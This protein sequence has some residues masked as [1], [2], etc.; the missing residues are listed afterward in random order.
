MKIFKFALCAA[1]LVSTA[2]VSCVTDETSNASIELNE[3]EF[4]GIASS[5]TKIS[6]MENLEIEPKLKGSLYGDDDTKY[7]YQWTICKSVD[8]YTHA[9]DFIS[10]E[11]KLDYF[12]DLAPGVYTVT[13]RVYDKDNGMNYEKT[14]TL[15][16]ESP[17]VRGFY[18][19]G[20]KEDGLAAMDFVSIITG[21]DTTLIKDVFDN[22]VG[23]KH[24]VDLVYTG[25]YSMVSDNNYAS[26]E[27]IF[28]LW[29]VGKDASY[30][31]ESLA[32]L[33][34]FGVKDG[35]RPENFIFSQYPLAQPTIVTNI[36][37][38]AFGSSNINRARSYRILTTTDEI[39]V[40]S[41]MSEEAYGDP[42][43]RY[44]A[45]S[46]EFF[47]P[48][49]YMFY[50]S[51][52]QTTPPVVVAYDL[53]NHKFCISNSTY[54]L[55]SATAFKT[56]T[57][58]GSIFYHDQ[59]KYTPVRDLIYGEN[60]LGRTGRCYALMGDANGGRWV[61][62]FT[63]PTSGYSATALTKVRNSEIDMTA[64]SEFAKAE[65][66]AFFSTQAYLLYSVGN[67]LY[68]LNYT[69]NTNK[70]LKEFS[71]EITYLAM[72]THSANRSGDLVVCTYNSSEK[73]KV[74]KY[75]VV[76]D[77]NDINI[78]Q[79]DYSPWSTDLKVVKVEYRNNSY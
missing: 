29:A 43:N 64:C 73:G 35:Q 23:M 27:H 51:N 38:H 55:S 3:V 53:T 16:V 34:K 19:F 56:P 33:V 61:Y 30:N 22:T 5:Y 6:K 4:D 2:L 39:F 70:L 13:F 40:T 77:P 71:G 8:A 60:G 25:N 67:K 10:E 76:D 69:T 66:M 47:K 20:E 52:S 21:R 32:T 9:H 44:S 42:I 74:Y 28:D 65:H 59:T 58:N 68:G 57:E 36:H 54:A 79:H 62:E 78:E 31:I 37:P 14:T 1:M 26:Y 15:R 11:K 45:T 24:P 18:L 48:S 72:E 46:K 7:R 12:V 50:G 63:C 17:F 41:T 49:P 75:T